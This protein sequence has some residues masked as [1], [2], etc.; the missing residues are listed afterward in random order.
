[1]MISL[2]AVLYDSALVTHI[3]GLTVMAGTAMHDRISTARYWSAIKKSNN[4]FSVPS[5][6]WHRYHRLLG[7]GLAILVVSGFC[8]MTQLHDVWGRQTWFRLKMAVL[9]AVIVNGLVIRP[10]LVR[11]MS[12]L[13]AASRAENTPEGLPPTTQWKRLAA[14]QACQ[15]LLLVTIYVLSVFKFDG[16][17]GTDGASAMAS[18]TNGQALYDLH[19]AACHGKDG[20]LRHAGATDL[21]ASTLEYQETLMIITRGRRAMPSFGDRLSDKEIARI[22]TYLADLRSFQQ[23]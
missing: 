11:K 15:L 22:A 1:M 9:L 19:C 10:A 8:M 20:R 18:S 13:T 14:S 21:S 3:I 4:R 7:V 23:D 17:P 5:P 2:K 6:P 12:T 16:T